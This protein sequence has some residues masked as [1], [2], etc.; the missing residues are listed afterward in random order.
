MS[1]NSLVTAFSVTSALPIS[2]KNSSQP[3]YSES[4]VNIENEILQLE[5]DSLNKNYYSDRIKVRNSAKNINCNE[6]I[7]V[8]KKAETRLNHDQER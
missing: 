7:N 4:I 6:Q 2:N 5:A 1:L 3:A 8:V